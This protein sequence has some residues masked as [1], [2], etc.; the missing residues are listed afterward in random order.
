MFDLLKI[1]MCTEQPNLVKMFTNRL[2]MVLPL[3]SW[4][5]KTVATHWYSE[6]KN[7]VNKEGHAEAPIIIDFHENSASYCQLLKAKFTLFIE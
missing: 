6:K 5:K 2:N 3:R 1:V 7:S 4:V